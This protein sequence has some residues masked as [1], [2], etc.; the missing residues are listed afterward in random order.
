MHLDRVQ[1]VLVLRSSCSYSTFD[2]S[3]AILESY[4]LWCNLRIM[5]EMG[6]TN[7][8]IIQVD[9]LG[10]NPCGFE[11]VLLFEELNPGEVYLMSLFN[12]FTTVN[13]IDIPVISSPSAFSFSVKERSVVKDNNHR[14]QNVAELD[15]LFD[16]NLAFVH[17]NAVKDQAERLNTPPFNDTISVVKEDYQPEAAIESEIDVTMRYNLHPGVN[18]I[19]K[20]LE[21][22]A[23]RDAREIDLMLHVLSCVCL[24]L[25]VSYPLMLAWVFKQNTSA[26]TPPPKIHQMNRLTLQ[27]RPSIT[28]EDSGE[29][30][31]DCGGSQKNRLTLQRTASISKEDSDEIAHGFGESQTNFKA[32]AYPITEGKDNGQNGKIS[33]KPNKSKKTV[34]KFSHETEAR[35]ASQNEPQTATPPKTFLPRR[36]QLGIMDYSGLPNFLPRPRSSVVAKPQKENTL[37]L[38]PCSRLKQD[39]EE[40]KRSTKSKGKSRVASRDHIVPIHVPETIG[41]ETT[42]SR[43]SIIPVEYD[44]PAATSDMTR[45]SQGEGSF[46]NEYW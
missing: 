33:V 24:V 44:L 8:A 23:E 17:L 37:Q 20:F 43:K 34:S 31:Y 42:P 39:W 26:V 21:K 22:N 15:V 40:K 9:E 32:D 10:L 27:G 18:E 6:S 3:Q 11:N 28:K 29:I 38:S 16:M 14:W 35:S 19:L 45:T 41:A 12:C 7:Y 25:L 4:P 30:A 1:S 46:L 5:P 36:S 2:K 13:K